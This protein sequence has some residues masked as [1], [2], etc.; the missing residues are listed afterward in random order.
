MKLLF[1]DCCISQRGEDSRTLRLAKAY[2]E[3]FWSATSGGRG[4]DGGA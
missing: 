4:G 3:R 2:L 1:V